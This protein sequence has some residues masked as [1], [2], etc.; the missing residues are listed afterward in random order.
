MK[1]KNIIFLFTVFLF[2]TSCNR[3]ESSHQIHFYY[4]KTDVHF[5]E[6]EKDYFRSLSCKKLFIR[7]FDIDLQDGLPSPIAKIKRFDAHV[8]PAEY[9]PV[10][11][12]TNRTF[13]HLSDEAIEDLAI[14][15]NKLI[16][17]IAS[18]NQFPN[19]HEINIDCDW[20]QSTRAAYFT[21]LKALRKQSGK[22][23]SCTLRL[24][25]IK[26]KKLTGIPP[27]AKG[28]LMCYAT[29]EPTANS[30]INSI[31]DISLLKSYTRNINEYPLAFD[32][33]LP[34]Y[35]WGIVTNHLGDK[36]L[37]NG[38]TPDDL[39]TPAFRATGENTFEVMQD[40]FLQGLYINKGFTIK[41]ELI[42]PQLL[43]EAKRYLH[44]KTDHDYDIVYFHLSKGFLKRFTIKELK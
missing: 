31:L 34:L 41:L 39:Q 14:N 9:V 35:S 13:T 23:V 17:D 28:Y 8:L 37:I 5:G 10:V 11:F 32:I 18:A 24:H 22:K 12:I 4:W 7:L 1:L 29:S 40:C 15:M 20:T 16:Q 25:Q 42:T 21:F 43:N 26:D 30:T 6:T 33:A 44:Q 3:D 19:I 27:V 36:K 2:A 38:L